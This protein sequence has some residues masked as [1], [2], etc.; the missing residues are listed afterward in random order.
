MIVPLL[1]ELFPISAS[2]FSFPGGNVMAATLN[3]LSMFGSIGLS[4][5]AVQI[6]LEGLPL[7]AQENQPRVCPFELI[8]QF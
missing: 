6:P 5:S 8:I 1:D 4:D 3:C 7:A 2:S